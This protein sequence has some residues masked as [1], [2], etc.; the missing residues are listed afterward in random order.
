VK[1]AMARVCGNITVHWHFCWCMPISFILCGGYL[2]K[3]VR[4]EETHQSL[5][6]QWA[7]VQDELLTLG[8][9]VLLEKQ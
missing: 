7:K 8:R 9:Q 2:D 5:C 4:D 3:G 6:S 1:V